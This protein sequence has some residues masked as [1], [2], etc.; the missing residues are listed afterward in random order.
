MNRYNGLLSKIAKEL[1][2]AKGNEESDFSFK[3]RIIYSAIG[4]VTYASLFDSMDDGQPISIVHF[5]NRCKNLFT[6]YKAIYPEI[7]S[8][9]EFSEDEFSDL[10][11]DLLLQTGSILHCP[12]RLSVP[13]PRKTTYKD[14]VFLRG[15]SISTK[16]FRSGL[17]PYLIQKDT[18]FQNDNLA[19][20][21]H[22][23]QES[24]QKRWNNI[25]KTAKWN[26]MEFSRNIE[27]LRIEPPFTKGYFTDKL[28]YEDKLTIAR[29]G[30]G[31]KEYCLCR[32]VS[33]KI[34]YS[35]LSP[36][37]TNDRKYLEIA[38]CCLASHGTLPNIKIHK[39]GNIIIAY[40]SYLLPPAEQNFFEL[41]SWPCEINPNKKSFERIFPVK[42]FDVVREKFENVGYTFIEV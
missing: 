13:F 33:G 23:S 40:L 2:I 20:M 9:W 38:N 3:T 29:F 41:Y 35:P 39:D 6:S 16:V 27:Y 42:V 4:H 18:D 34:E 37:E 32:K 25:I 1:N 7:I 21:F 10:V 19:S 26:V 24:L 5:K 14:V 17:G 22:M 8:T 31:Y 12:N 30:I 15:F 28:E 36:W 11:Y